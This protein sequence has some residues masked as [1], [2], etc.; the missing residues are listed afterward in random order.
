MAILPWWL[1][2]A[3][4]VVIG[5]VATVFLLRKDAADPLRSDRPALLFVGR[6]L[7]F[8]YAGLGLIG[9]VVNAIATLVG[10]AVRVAL[11]VQQFWP[12][13]YPWIT[14]DPA[15]ATSVVGG[16]FTTAD[17]LVTGLGTDARML[18]AAGNAVQGLTFVVIA[19]VIGF[20]CHRLLGGSPFRPLLARSMTWAAVAITAGGIAWQILLEIGGS[21]ASRQVLEVTGWRADAPTAGMMDYLNAN[22]DTFDT[23]LPLPYTGFQLEFWPLLL[24]LA[25]AVVAIAFRYS[26]RL[27]R[28]TEGLV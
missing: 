27:Q 25:L 13:T 8:L 2:V 22:F 28:D 15:P 5:L 17:A 23:G 4:F 3:L 16:G 7:A 26:E 1:V 24:G 9:T 12:E 19:A 6:F 10:D 14:L 20:L 11:P 18:L 21:L